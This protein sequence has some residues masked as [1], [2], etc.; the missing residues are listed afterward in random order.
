MRR[1]PTRTNLTTVS[2]P[3]P[4]TSDADERRDQPHCR[5]Q[6]QRQ[7]RAETDACRR[8]ERAPQFDRRY[9]YIRLEQRGLLQDVPLGSDYGT[10]AAR[11]GNHDGA[12][13][14]DGSHPR[15]RQLLIRHFRIAERGV[16]GGDRDE[17]RTQ[18][19]G[20]VEGPIE[21]DFVTRG[22]SGRYSCSVYDTVSISRNEIARSIG[23]FRKQP[24]KLRYGKYSPKG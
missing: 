9:Q 6:N 11:R 1:I 10:D 23:V 3:K 13:V 4:S 5:G 7:L 24:K 21:C 14:F 2:F 8:C 16:V 19:N 22:Y 12:S 15:H 17:L 18:T 20:L